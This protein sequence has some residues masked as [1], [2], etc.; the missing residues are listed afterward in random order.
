MV[1]IDYQKL[2]LKLLSPLKQKQRSYS[3]FYPQKY[4]T[5]LK[6]QVKPNN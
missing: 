5:N 4:F 1:Q 3:H 6:L 2:T